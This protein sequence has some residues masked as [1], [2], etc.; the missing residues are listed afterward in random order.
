[1]IFSAARN[2]GDVG[3]PAIAA[4]AKKYDPSRIYGQ[5][6]VRKSKENRYLT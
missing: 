4:A 3:G 1:L 2:R 6:V 5:P